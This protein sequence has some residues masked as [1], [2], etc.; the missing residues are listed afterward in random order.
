MHTPI[1][2]RQLRGLVLHHRQHPAEHPRR[3]VNRTATRLNER[4]ITL[5]HLCRQAPCNQTLKLAKAKFG[6][7]YCVSSGIFASSNSPRKFVLATHYWLM[8]RVNSPVTPELYVVAST[9]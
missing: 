6:A 7:I 3:L 1:R 9:V 5:S 4:V 8:P 2:R